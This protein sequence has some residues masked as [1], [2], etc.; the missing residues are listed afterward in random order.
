MTTSRE[1]ILQALFARLETISDVKVLRNEVLPEKIPA[2]GLIIL[3]DGDAGQPEVSLSPLSYYWQH[4]A[5]LEVLVTHSNAAVRDVALDDLF[6]AIAAVIAEDR[7]LGGLCDRVVPQAP[8]VSTLGI[9]GAPS[10]KA[11]TV[12]IELI[13][14]TA[15][16]LG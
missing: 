4:Q 14:M 16:Q 6:A 1:I 2:S 13:Y 10:V 8:L 7:T 15:D 5:S 9:D 12:G 3:R 11:A